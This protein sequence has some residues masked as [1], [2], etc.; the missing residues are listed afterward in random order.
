MPPETKGQRTRSRIVE[1]AAA[2]FNQRGYEGTSMQDVMDATGLKK[3][4]L[5]RHF[6][7][8]EQLAGEAFR[9]AWTEAMAGRTRDLDAIP[10]A[11]PRLRHMIE[12]F[13]TMRGPVPG[14][15]PLM[16]MAIEADDGNPALR[17]LAHEALREWQGRIVAI[18]RDGIAAKEIARSVNP[19]RLANRIIATL[20]GA[21]MISRLERSREALADAQDNLSAELDAIA[22]PRQ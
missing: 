2:V 22:T 21:L 7:S 6:S 9:Y 11:L 17:A 20:E 4:G 3:G 18:V 15:C 12:R 5:Y 10:G 19:R 8:K 14:G 13:V 1:Q 16:N